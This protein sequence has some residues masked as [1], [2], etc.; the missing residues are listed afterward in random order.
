MRPV[1]VRT[2]A[3]LAWLAASAAS[4]VSGQPV[5]ITPGDPV[6]ADLAPGGSHTFTWSTPAGQLVDVAVRQD[7]IDL[8]AT[9]TGPD[10]AVLMR[11]DVARGTRGRERVLAIAP[12]DTAYRLEVRAPEAD[13]AS[14]RFEVVLDEPR[15]PTAADHGRLEAVRLTREAERLQAEGSAPTLQRAVDLYRQARAAWREAGDAA[16]EARALVEEASILASSGEA[17]RGLAP[18]EEAVTLAAATGDTA[19]EGKALSTKGEVHEYL[20][21]APEG[22]RFYEQAI[23][24]RAAAGDV[25]GECETV[26]HLAG[27][28]GQLGEGPRAMELHERSLALCRR[29]GD[30]RSIAIN[31]NNIGLLHRQLGDYEEALALY[32]E[33]LVVHEEMGRRADQANAHNNIGKAYEAMGDF[34]N[35]F[36]S[37]ERALPLWRA[38]GERRG[39]AITLDNMGTVLHLMGDDARALE[40]HQEALRLWRE[41][42][43]RRLEAFTLDGLGVVHGALG[44]PA[45]ALALHEEALALRLETGDRRGEGSTLAKLGDAL[46][47]LGRLEE[48]E[49]RY[50]SALERLRAVQ[51]RAG[52]A[53][54]LFA[55]A[56][57]ARAR[58]EPDQSLV[59]IEGAL[60]ILESLRAGMSS[61]DLRIAFQASKQN[62][63]RFLVDLLMEME[64]ARP[65]QGL[66]GRALAAAERVKARS[67]LELLQEGRVD[68]REGVDATLLER[69]RL[70]ARRLN[71]KELYRSRLLAGRP[72]EER[73]AAVEKEVAELLAEHALVQSE[74]RAR[75]P[76][77]AALT[78]PQPMDAPS[79]Q[80]LLDDDTVL[81]EYALGEERSHV[82]AV[83]RTGLAAYVL[84]GRA[85]IEAAARRFHERATRSHLRAGRRPLEVAG[86]ELSGLLLGPVASHLG[87]Q[88][89]L[90]VGDGV[91]QY[92]PFAAL[93]DP[94]DATR[95]L[96]VAHEIVSLPSASVLGVLR[97]ERDVPR[98]TRM[99]AVLS[100]PVFDAADPRVSGARKREAAGRAPVPSELT[101][102]LD[103]LALDRLPRLTR[104]R[105]EAEA[106]LALAPP[107]QALGALDFAASRATATDPALGDYR[108]VHFASHGLLNSRHPQLSGIV[109]SLVDEEGRPQ[110]GFLRLHDVYNLRFRAD[111]VVLSA[112]QT[113]LGKDVRGEGLVGLTRGFLHAGARDVVASL[114]SVR[115]DAT[116]E[117]MRRFYRALLRDG[118]TPSAALRTAQVSMW[119]EPRWRAP[120]HWAGFV[121]QGDWR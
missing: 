30:R 12:Q 103:E 116:A 76:R 112:C 64:R 37:F 3:L 62:S 87:G 88:R 33:T 114:W 102:A 91:L 13:L 2:P 90:V 118:Q 95:P 22:V 38:A 110:D 55:L 6:Q 10:G 18:V 70:L 104:S 5:A 58:G 7:G 63:Y 106:I 23:P 111:L 24:L 83:S 19:L 54:A 96:V 107:G 45:Q 9:L 97:Q 40:R 42:K 15:P 117:L 29:V 120:Y 86:A 79:I 32:R 71:S 53:R 93:P 74:I 59:H 28:V 85:R 4:A 98:P 52:E 81:L 66:A 31:L 108:A 11:S 25:G 48:A 80:A 82:W 61:P 77:Y 94:A 72:G 50:A 99:V 36:A 65:G 68:I 105:Q 60:S 41:S 57:V 16:G 115:D 121:V 43:N 49:R 8:V 75:S 73:T 69:E 1:A 47:Q 56:R 39:E 67:L 44:D 17:V 26:G 34:D 84:P 35:A 113:A 92:V 14:G 51:D 78:Q 100:D 89:L 109:L 20:G 119:K 27:A 101:R 21:R 46:E